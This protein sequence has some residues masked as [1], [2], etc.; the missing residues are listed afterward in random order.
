MKLL[1]TNINEQD[2]EGRTALMLAVERGHSAVVAKLVKDGADVGLKDRKG[3][4]AVLL[5]K[6][7]DMVDQLVRDV[8]D[9]SKEDCSRI[10]WH[11]CDFGDLSM[12]QSVIEAGCDVD[13]IHKG[14]TPVMMATLRGHDSIV[15][16]LILE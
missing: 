15:K 5:A 4:T 1:E 14:Q 8:D 16:E 12:V 13:H 11:A 3:M 10:L 6:S 2:D 7:Y 9:L